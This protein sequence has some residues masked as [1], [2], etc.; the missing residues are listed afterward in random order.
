MHGNFFG[1]T[2]IIEGD[3]GMLQVI[4]IKVF[5][6]LVLLIACANDEVGKTLCSIDLHD[7]PKNGPASDFDH[8][9]RTQ[10]ALFR[11]PCSKSTC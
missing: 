7:V 10:V 9:L 2:A 3:I 5:L 11:D 6:D 4:V 8:W 1:A